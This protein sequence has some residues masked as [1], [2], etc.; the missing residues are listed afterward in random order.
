VKPIELALHPSYRLA[1]LLAGFSLGTCVIVVCM[2]MTTGLKFIICVAV[3]LAAIYF[4]AQDVLLCLPWSLLRLD[5]NSK[6]EL[7]VT[8]GRGVKIAVAVLPSSFVAAYLTVLNLKLEGNIWCRNLILTPD[9]AD[10]DAFRRLRVWLRWHHDAT[11]SLELDK[12]AT[13]PAINSKQ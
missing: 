4:I 13:H 11:N 9:R 8:D 7:K 2:P 5:L 3:V 1:A 10:R 12:S 6:G